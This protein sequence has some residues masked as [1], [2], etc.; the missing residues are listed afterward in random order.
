M[1]L[2]INCRQHYQSFDTSPGDM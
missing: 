2:A 1:Y